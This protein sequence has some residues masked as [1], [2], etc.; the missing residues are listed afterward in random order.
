MCR[1]ANHQTRL[2]RATSSLALNAF[3]DGAS[4]TSCIKF[5]LTACYPSANCGPGNL[6][7][8]SASQRW[9]WYYSYQF[10]SSSFKMSLWI[11]LGCGRDAVEA[12][13]NMVMP[14][15]SAG[16]CK[17]SIPRLMV[18]KSPKNEWW[19][20]QLPIAITCLNAIN[21]YKS[22]DDTSYLLLITP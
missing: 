14:K 11:Y 17:K 10:E 8:N 19:S 15:L 2:P 6:L 21:S 7:W 16:K 3:R 18:G 5:T 4:T 1:V 22:L 9:G 13:S 20:L 12:E